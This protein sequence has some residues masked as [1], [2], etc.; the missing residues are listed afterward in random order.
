M[1]QPSHASLLPTSPILILSRAACCCIGGRVSR[2]AGER[3]RPAP[4]VEGPDARTAGMCAQ[5]PACAGV[6][7]RGAGDAAGKPGSIAPASPIWRPKSANCCK[8]CCS[9]KPSWRSGCAPLDPPVA[10]AHQLFN[11]T[12]RACA[13]TNWNAICAIVLARS[14]IFRETLFS[15]GSVGK[16][17]R[18]TGGTPGW[19]TSWQTRH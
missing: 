10:P 6:S 2:D 12:C 14:R 15:K 1:R 3:C 17:H 18:I 7:G 4:D 9:G 13:G 16:L 5:R 8:W 19:S 11:M